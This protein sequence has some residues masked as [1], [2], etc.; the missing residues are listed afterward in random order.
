MNSIKR[1]TATAFRLPMTGSLRWGKASVLDEVR[2]VLVE[3]ELNDGSIGLAEAPPRPTIYGET[4]YSILSIIEHELGPRLLNQPL[5]KVAARLDEIKNNQ[6]AKGAL[7]MALQDALAQQ[8]GVSLAQHL[9]ATVDRVKVSYILGI[10]D[11]DTVLA[12]AERVFAQ[13]VRVLKVKVGRDWDD[14]LARIHD[15]Q[16]MFKGEMALYADANECLEVAAAADKLAHL[17]EIGLLYCEEPLPVELI[18]ERATLRRQQRLPI[19]ADDSCFSYRDLQRELALDTFD[20]LNIK[21]ARTGYTE[22]RRMMSAAQA[23]G[24]TIM[25]G[26]QASASLGTVRA[27]LF[28]ALPGIDHPS[29]LSF[30]LKVKE[31][32]L[33]EPLALDDG[34]FDVTRFA[35]AQVDRDLLRRAAV[36]SKTVGQ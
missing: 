13:G 23:Q 1:I 19:I 31:D 28:A 21:T 29:E 15:L 25:I 27:A 3:V 26:S 16:A 17:R 30:F 34:Y 5:E 32:I 35:A 4:V 12:E 7:D 14:D 20:I 22:S 24:K 33:S 2:H 8:R 6:T 36:I 10:G 9:G 18:R 11:R